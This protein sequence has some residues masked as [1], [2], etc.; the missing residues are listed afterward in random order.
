MFMNWQS[1]CLSRSLIALALSASDASAHHVGGRTP[2]TFAEGIFSCFGHSIIA[3]DHFAAVVAMGC[4][5]AVHPAA[6]ALVVALALLPAGRW[7]GIPI[8]LPCQRKPMKHVIPGFAFLR[9]TLECQRYVYRWIRVPTPWSVN[10]SSKTACGTL[11][12]RMTTPSTPW[13]SA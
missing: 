1:A 11:P 3:L 8:I 5:A 13:S 4:L 12:S 2:K 7:A 6:V 9:G 10:N